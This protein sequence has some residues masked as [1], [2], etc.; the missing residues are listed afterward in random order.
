MLTPWKSSTRL[1]IYIN[2]IVFTGNWVQRGAWVRAPDMERM[3]ERDEAER[4]EREDA[5]P[6]LPSDAERGERSGGGQTNTSS[7]P[8]GGHSQY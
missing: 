6:L 8:W 2:R 5:P 1:L 4:R 7:K 3:E